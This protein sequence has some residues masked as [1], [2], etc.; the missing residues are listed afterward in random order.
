M[1]EYTFGVVGIL[2]WLTYDWG[3]Q[4]ELRTLF[5]LPVV[6]EADVPVNVLDVRVGERWVLRGKKGRSEF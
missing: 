1:P 4:G 2:C 3:C 6:E 5:A